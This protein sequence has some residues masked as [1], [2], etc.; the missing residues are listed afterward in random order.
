MALHVSVDPRP[1]LPRAGADT[2]GLR[3]S[4]WRAVHPV[5]VKEPSGQT[6]AAPGPASGPGF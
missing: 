3:V 5:I 4:V 1:A 2:G 6:G